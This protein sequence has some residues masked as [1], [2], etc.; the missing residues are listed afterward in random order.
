M[1]KK[2]TFAL[3]ALLISMQSFAQK[4]FE[5]KEA[6][7]NGYPYKY[8]TNDPMNARFYTLKNGLTVILSPTKTDPR[9]QAYVA[10]KAGS[11]TDPRTN[12]GL[13]HYLEHMLFKGTDKFGSLDWAKE[14]PQLDKIDGLYEQYNK[15][16]DSAQRKAIY[17]KID[18]VSGV[19]SKFAIA[20]EYD[21]MMASMGAQ[22]TNAFTSFEQTVYTDDVPSSSLDKYLAVQG[23]RFRNPILRIFHTELEAV[24][25]EKNRSLDSDGSKVFE[26]LFSELFKNHNYGQQTTIGT[27]EHLKNPSLVEI[28]KYFHTY[29]VPNNMGVIL[30]GDFNPDE[31]IAKVDKAFSNMKFQEVPKYTFTPETAIAKPIIKEIT[32]PDAENLTM[33]FRLPGNKD[34]DVLIADLVGQVLTNGKAGLMDLNLVKKQKLLRASAQTFT[35]IDYGVL[36]ISAAPTNGQSLDEVKTLV[37]GEIDNLKKGNF[38]DDLITSIINNIKK[39]KIYES[40]KY[41]DRASSLM[42]AFTSE[43]NWRDQVAYVNDLSKITKADIVKFANKYLGENYVAILKRKGESA[44]TAKIEKPQI[45]PVETN[46]DKQSP[47]VKMIGDMPNTPSVPVFLD[48]NKDI[49]KSKLG[50]AEVL[51]VPNKDNQIFRLKYRYKVGSLNDLKQPIASQYLQFL[52]TDKMSAEEISKAFYKIACSFNVSTSE[53][54]TTVSIEGL[55]ENFDQAVKLYEDLIQNVKADDAA[56]KGLKDRMAKARKD[57]KANKGAILQGLTSYAIYGKENKFNNVLSDSDLNSLTSTELVNR[58]KN[59]NQYEQTVIYYGPISIKELDAKLK[60]AHQVPAKFA[61]ALAAKTF[62]QTAQTKNKVLFADYDMVQAETRWIRNTEVYDPSK[63]TVVKVFNNYFGGGMGS[64]VFQTI[65]ESK[66]LAYSTYGVYVQPQK[67]DQEYY[68]M[69]Y[70]GSQA[71]KFNDATTAMNE[72]LTKMPDLPVNLDLAR[73]QVKKDIQTERITQDKIIFNYL[74]AKDLG[75]TEDVRK[76]LYNTVDKITMPEL[77][78]FHKTNFSGKPYTYSIVASEKKVP[79]SDMQK[80]GEV[81]KVSLEELFGY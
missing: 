47:F 52:G 28:R 22:G 46:A 7:G 35:L 16:K 1:F 55:Q 38:D 75:S 76:N 66:A 78:N 67:K 23:E 2:L 56:L 77:E 19:A 62:K 39:D 31:V 26:A 15:T 73:I 25:E 71:D 5:W 53:D 3:A 58:I 11:K 18:S 54:Y 6:S 14:K 74:A 43:L 42:D 61:V 20:N 27:V 36:Y 70:V 64:I 59:L 4:T 57:T 32:G 24:Y 40:E 29:Y 79:L 51:F 12:T 68:M 63:N 48:Y 72:L 10:V 17:K 13:A 34:K 45:T 69:S 41:D 81:Q 9:I 44:K 49:Q 8:V 65:R 60:A 37:L 80:L 21:K 33:G 30:S 50:N